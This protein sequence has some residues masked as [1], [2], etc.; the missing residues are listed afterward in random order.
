LVRRAFLIPVWF[1]HIIG[2]LQWERKGNAEET[3]PNKVRSME[4]RG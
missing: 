2:S 3:P 1:N 4:G